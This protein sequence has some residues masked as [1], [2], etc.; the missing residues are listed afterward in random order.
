[1]LCGVDW[2]HNRRLNLPEPAVRR[3]WQGRAGLRK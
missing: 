2:D 1:M 3:L